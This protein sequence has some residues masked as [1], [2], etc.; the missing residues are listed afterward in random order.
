MGRTRVREITRII[1]PLNSLQFSA[2]VQE[3]HNVNTFTWRFVCSP[4]GFLCPPRWLSRR[5]LYTSQTR[6]SQRT[7]LKE[8]EE[9]QDTSSVLMYVNIREIQI[10]LQ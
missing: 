8:K 6:P 10:N 7:Q 4:H 1:E 5:A 9:K 3:K 2:G